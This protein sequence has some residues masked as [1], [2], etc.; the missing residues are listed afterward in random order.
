MN[1]ETVKQEY[2]IM[3]DSLKRKIEDELKKFT[4]STFFVDSQSF[5]IVDNIIKTDVSA[6]FERSKIISASNDD[7]KNTYRENDS[8]IKDMIANLKSL[9]INNYNAKS[10]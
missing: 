2:M 4:Y 8:R 3:Y 10:Q 5:G 1:I 9:M 7:D 6:L